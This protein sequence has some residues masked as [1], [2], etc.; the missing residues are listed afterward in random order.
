[1]GQQWNVLG[2]RRWLLI[3]LAWAIP[4]ISPGDTLSSIRTVFVIVME[5]NNWSSIE[6]STNAPYINGT[7]L[8]MASFCEAYYN[9]P[10]VHPSLSGYLWLEAGTN[11]GIFDDNPPY[12]D[13]LSCTNHLVTLLQNAGVSWKAYQEDI[14]GDTVPLGD[15]YN[16]AVRH[17]PFVYFDDI[18]G[19]NTPTWPYGIAHI[20]P[21]AELTG[22]L[23]N[24]TV[25]RY[26]FIT[27][28]VCHDMHDIC[29]PLLNPV[30]QGDTWLAA[31]VPKIMAS[32]AYTNNGALF[33]TWDESGIG[34]GPIGLL[35]LSPL[36]WGNGYSNHLYYTHSSLVRT[37]QEIFGVAPLLNDAANA[38][39]LSDLFYYYGFRNIMSAPAGG[40]SLTAVGIVPG[41][42]N[43]IQA[44][45]DLSEWTAIGTNC[46]STNTFTFLDYSVTN[47][48]T[49]FYRL[50]QQP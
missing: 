47:V 39:D 32:A 9:P 8:P 35:A 7:L 19:T 18:T 41:M 11:F 45:S 42:T 50:Q 37:V 44:T 3:G 25:A 23:T 34:D 28:N 6:G 29:A 15:Y 2:R 12:L 30:Q 26:N 16:Y 31:E 27:P 24:N 48:A 13:H 46:V 5:N 17:D 49:R 36:A 1:V 33:I 43:I 10:G 4:W 22:D 21:Y 40:I 38:R 14:A 20:R